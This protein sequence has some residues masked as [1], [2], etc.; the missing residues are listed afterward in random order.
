M[1]LTGFL[2]AAVFIVFCSK[3]FGQSDK[4]LSIA[5]INSFV[6]PATQNYMKG[7]YNGCISFCNMAVKRLEDYKKTMERMP[8]TTSSIM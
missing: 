7:D 1:R 5:G 2:C 6:D 8:I 4:E 3:G